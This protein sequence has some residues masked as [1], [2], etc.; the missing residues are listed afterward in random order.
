MKVKH[1]VRTSFLTGAPRASVASVEHLLA[2]EPFLVVLDRGEFVGILTAG[3]IVETQHQLVIDCVR[4]KPQVDVNEDVESTLET[5]KR[6]GNF[7][8]PVFQAKEFVG[9][10][11]RQRITEYLLDYRDE[12]EQRVG[13]RTEALR[14]IETR[15][16]NMIYS[17]LDGIVVVDREGTIRYIN[18][19]AVSLFGRPAEDLLD[20]PFGFPVVPGSSTDVDLVGAAGKP[21]TAEMRASQMEWQ[22]ESVCLVFLRDIT[23]RKRGEE[24]T[25][26]AKAADEANRAKD[27]FLANMSHELR[28]PLNAVIGFSEGLLDRADRHPLNDHQKDRIA[29]ILQSGQH[30]LGLIND[31]LDIAKIEAGKAELDITTFD[32]RALAEEVVSVGEALTAEKADVTFSLDL[33][34]DLPPLTSDRSKVKQILLNLVSNAVKF[35]IRGSVA[36]W[37]RYLDGDIQMSVED[38]GVGIPEDQLGHIFERF[39]RLNGSSRAS[40]SGTGLGLA[41][42]KSYA[43]LLGGQLTVKSAVGQG[44]T[45]ALCLPIAANPLASALTSV[46]TAENLRCGSLALMA[47]DLS[48][49]DGRSPVEIDQAAMQEVRGALEQCIIGTKDTV[50]PKLPGTGPGDS[51]HVAACTDPGGAEVLAQ[52]IRQRLEGREALRDA[53]LATRIQI[54]MIDLPHEMRGTPPEQLARDVAANI[55]GLLTTRSEKANDQRRSPSRLA[56]Q[57][58]VRT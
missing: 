42:A 17:N 6:T 56:S 13:E 9:A 12:L 57:A 24:A 34:D 7:V 31:I 44:T 11:D 26:R 51:V 55:R 21:V 20:Q 54:T 30:L 23:D 32:M 37:I 8:L 14:Q 2:E 41:I 58:G 47:V 15:F 4:P 40:T 27:E 16:R 22:G 52:R 49:V 46:L 45:V 33:E 18:P 38:T 35:T 3:D 36:L 39:V 10:V 48:P 53:G 19:A 29:R 28:T 43:A 1:W 5:M 50:L 25:R